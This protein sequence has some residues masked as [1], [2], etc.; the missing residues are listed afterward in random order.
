MPLVYFA[1]VFL[2]IGGFMIW[3]KMYRKQRITELKKEASSDMNKETAK[4]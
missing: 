3:L 4:K 2:A 1:Y